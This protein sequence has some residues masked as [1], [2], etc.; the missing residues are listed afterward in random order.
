MTQDAALSVHVTGAGCQSGG[1]DEKQPAAS[2]D[3]LT[4]IECHISK[5]TKGATDII[6][7]M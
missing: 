5:K 2:T 3:E 1:H 7:T 6:M 4:L